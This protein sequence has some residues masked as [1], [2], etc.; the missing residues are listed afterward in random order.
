MWRS[1]GEGED[2]QHYIATYAASSMGQMVGIGRF[3][4]MV[5]W[6]ARAMG[7]RPHGTSPSDGNDDVEPDLR[8]WRVHAGSSVPLFGSSPLHFVQ[9]IEETVGLAFIASWRILLLSNAQESLIGSTFAPDYSRFEH[10]EG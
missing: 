5:S 1:L 4:W 9:V 10:H 2:E 8:T 7:L 6:S 3:A